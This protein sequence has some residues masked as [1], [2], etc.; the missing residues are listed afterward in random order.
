VAFHTPR[1]TRPDQLLE[2]RYERFLPCPS[3]FTDR[4]HVVVSN[5]KG[6]LQCIQHV[7]NECGLFNPDTVTTTESDASN[8]LCPL[9]G[10]CVCFV[11]LIDWIIVSVQFE[12]NGRDLL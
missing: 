3:K 10:Q 11:T 4:I 5:A 7:Y 1:R 12:R 9:T 6:P 8:S 2:I